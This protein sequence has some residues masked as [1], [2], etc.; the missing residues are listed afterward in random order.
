[1]T[2]FQIIFEITLLLVP[3]LFLQ[4]ADGSLDIFQR[5]AGFLGEVEVGFSQHFPFEVIPFLSTLCPDF[6]SVSVV[7]SHF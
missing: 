2:L 7:C 6:L 5:N 3:R 1:M 4:S